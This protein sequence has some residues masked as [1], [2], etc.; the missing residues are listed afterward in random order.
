ME[1]RAAFR[2]SGTATLTAAAVTARLGI[3]PTSAFEAGDPVSSRSAATRADSLWLLSSSP[4]IETDT[5]LIQHL[6]RLL[7]TLEPA[8]QALWELTR[9][10][11]HA[12]WSCYIASHA[13]EHAAELDRQT[14]Q[15]ILALPGDLW[16]DVSGDDTSP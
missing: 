1:T 11:Y 15:R 2:L 6:H 9:A 14:L 4:R 12:N 10:G 3:Q 13:T 16:L 5:E 7:A 8:T